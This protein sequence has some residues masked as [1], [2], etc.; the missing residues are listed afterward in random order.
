MPLDKKVNLNSTKGKPVRLPCTCATIRRASRSVTQLYDLVLTPSGIKTP[1][2][3]LLQHL[4]EGGAIAQ[5]Q[6]GKNLSIAVA[7]LTR[8]LAT[9]RKGGWIESSVGRDFREH[10]Y[11]ITDAGRRQFERSLPYWK[12]AQT[13][14]HEALRDRTWTDVH[15]L[16][17]HLVFAAE[18]AR[19]M[20]RRNVPPAK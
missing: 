6:L 10:T 8:R 13:R 3:I 9:M 20:R 4:A 5:W 1:Q 2:F 11:R 7:T 15:E 12:L 16:L 14:L 19:T 18:D 17:D